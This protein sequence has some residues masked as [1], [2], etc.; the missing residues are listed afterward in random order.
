MT[1]PRFVTQIRDILCTIGLPQLHFAG[2]SFR[3]G[4]A[5][6][7][8]AVGMEDSAIQMLGRWHSTAFLQYIRTPKERLAALLTT[9]ATAT[10]SYRFVIML[11]KYSCIHTFPLYKIIQEIRCM[12]SVHLYRSASRGHPRISYQYYLS[13]KVTLTYT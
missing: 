4:A 2:H 6:T 1:K 10:N 13:T 3:I 7:A 8:A 11:Y 5:T 12:S 9:L